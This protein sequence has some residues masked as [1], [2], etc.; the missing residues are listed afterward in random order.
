MQKMRRTSGHVSL[1]CALLLAGAVTPAWSKPGKPAAAK[2][3][4]SKTSKNQAAKGNSASANRKGNTADKKSAN[5]TPTS[6][7]GTKTSTKGSAHAD[8]ALKA[9]GVKEEGEAGPFGALA[10]LREKLEK[11]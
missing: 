11:K 8:A 7:K 2:A 3:S 9:A 10:A 1:V 6:K 4:T 5:A